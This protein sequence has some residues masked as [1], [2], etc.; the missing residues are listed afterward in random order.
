[1]ARLAPSSPTIRPRRL[2]LQLPNRPL[3]SSRDS[4]DS[5]SEEVK[6]SQIRIMVTPPPEEERSTSPIH[7]I[8]PS[9]SPSPERDEQP[10]QSYE[11]L[12]AEVARLREENRELEERLAAR[13]T[14][15]QE[16]KETVTNQRRLLDKRPN[17][18]RHALERPTK[19]VRFDDDK[20]EHRPAPRRS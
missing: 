2:R 5:D 17:A 15:I 8:S 10:E 19:R 14:E 16:L 3:S 13:N 6:V 9:P 4:N 20:D 18:G 12:L 7:I 11:E 1:M